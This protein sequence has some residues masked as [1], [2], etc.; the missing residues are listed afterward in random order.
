[1]RILGDSY[2]RLDAALERAGTE[3][4]Y[5]ESKGQIIEYYK[6][7]YGEKNWT[8]QIAKDLQPFTQGK[9]GQPLKV[10]SI[11]RRF[12]GDRA[13]KAAGKTARG[14][15]EQFKKLGKE[16]PGTPVPRK[17]L[18]GKKAKVDVKAR[19]KIS[20][21]ERDRKF[22]TTLSGGQ[23]SALRRGEIGAIFEAYGVNP[24]AVETLRINS[25][26]VDYL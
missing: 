5:L 8:R 22:S 1:M 12:Q 11:M 23:A 13:T 16:L 2:E 20:D 15:N 21:D 4:V 14:T 9:N 18:A 6:Q 10:E 17:D 25:I 7:E 3:I 19:I 24:G 26:S